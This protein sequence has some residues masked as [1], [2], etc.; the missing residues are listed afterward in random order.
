MTDPKERAQKRLANKVDDIPRVQT[1]VNEFSRPI[2]TCARCGHQTLGCPR[3]G[4]N[5]PFLGA[6]WKDTKFCHTFSETYPTCYMLAT[7]SD[8]YGP[9]Y[10]D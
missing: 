7:R 3:C 4:K 1:M 6:G 9:F 5:D 10:R 2:E 8:D